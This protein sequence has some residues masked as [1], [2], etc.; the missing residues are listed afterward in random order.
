VA[1]IILRIGRWGDTGIV[2]WRVAVI[3]IRRRIAVIAV[4]IVVIIGR[5]PVRTP[6]PP[7]GPETAETIKPM[8]MEMAVSKEPPTSEAVPSTISA[9]SPA[10]VTTPKSP[11]VVTTPKPPATSTASTT[12]RAGGGGGFGG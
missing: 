1:V 9:K 10:A 5:P 4:V 8:V 3:V 6:K 11:A 2:C 7:A 12:S